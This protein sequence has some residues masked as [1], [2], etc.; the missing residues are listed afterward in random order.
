MGQSVLRDSNPTSSKNN[1]VRPP[2][3]IS[4]NA[5]SSDLLSDLT[6]SS[7]ANINGTVN[8][9]IAD[10]RRKLVWVAVLLCACLLF[11]MA[12]MIYMVSP[13]EQWTKNADAL[14]ECSLLEMSGLSPDA[15]GI[16]RFGGFLPGQAICSQ[17]NILS[18]EGQCGSDCFW[19]PDIDSSDLVCTLPGNTVESM[20]SQ[21]TSRS[22]DCSC[23]EMLREVCE[24]DLVA[25]DVA[26]MTLSFAAQNLV[27]AIVGFNMG[28]RKGNLSL[29]ISLFSTPTRDQSEVLSEAGRE[30]SDIAREGAGGDTFSDL[31]MTSA[32][33]S[34]PTGLI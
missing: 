6:V 10:T 2:D 19:R 12:L 34:Q 30:S 4:S 26:V 14:L 22:C 32:E 24:T 17:A 33:D 13:L 3:D 8:K 11:A 18:S 28:F 20:V 1:M 23:E 9:S 31:A 29:W 5:N 25:N 21:L 27:V 15:S 16:S 7:I